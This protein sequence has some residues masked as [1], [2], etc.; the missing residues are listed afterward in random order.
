LQPLRQAVC[1]LQVD[2]PLALAEKLADQTGV[3]GI[4]FEEQNL[5]RIVVD[6]TRAR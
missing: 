4:V 3:A 6:S 5:E 2:G 1:P